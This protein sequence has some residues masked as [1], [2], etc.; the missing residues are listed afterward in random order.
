MD[1]AGSP[2]EVTQSH[3]KLSTQAIFPQLGPK[4]QWSTLWL[5]LADLSD[6]FFSN[7]NNLEQSE[8]WLTSISIMGS[9]KIRSI[10]LAA[11]QLVSGAQGS[12]QIIFPEAL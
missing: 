2:L 10:S 11:A 5:N 4:Q 12:H 3:I 6:K 1:G 8:V 9:F 7:G